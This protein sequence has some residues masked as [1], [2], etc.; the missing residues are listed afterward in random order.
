MNNR[1]L[2]ECVGNVHIHSLYSDGGGSVA[3]IAQAASKNG[4]DF[5]VLN[6]HE[7]MTDSLHL[8]EEGL[9]GKVL[10][11]MGIE[12]GERYHHYLAF[13]IREIIRG[14]GLSPQ[15]IIDRVGEQQGLGF[16]AHPFEKGMP[17]HEH[18]IAYTWNDLEV[19]RYTGIGIWNFLSRWK[20][21][22]RSPMHGLW[23][24][25]FKQ[26]SLKGPSRRTLAFW[27]SKCRERR[28]AAIGGSDAHGHAFSFGLLRF[29][30]FSYRVLLNTIN[31]HILL[32]EHLS[33]EFTQ[34]KEQ[35]FRAIGQ[36]R[37]FIAHDGLDSAR[38]FAFSYETASRKTWHMGEEHDFEPG[39]VSVRLPA[40]C[41]IRLVRNGKMAGE[42]KG[43]NVRVEIRQEG[44]YRIE[45]E[46]HVPLFGWKAWI[47]SNPIYL[48]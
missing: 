8:E 14:R 34:A 26:T 12:I 43:R 22:V 30:P 5:I 29:K 20:E 41:R 42:W 25:L 31:L 48:R 6:D 44:V 23:C 40:S 33:A 39:T 16:L 28:V 38:G 2:F 11:L 36:G 35:I 46:K 19:E 7:Y 13:N 17:F 37:L 21:R 9:R 47:F 4:L 32:R 3:D 45:V 27:D 1:E 24:L 10:V 18:S 15:E